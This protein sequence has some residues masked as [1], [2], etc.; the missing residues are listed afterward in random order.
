MTDLTLQKLLY[1]KHGQLLTKC[2]DFALC[3]TIYGPQRVGALLL[4]KV[5]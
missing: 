4:E 3:M 2:S 1:E 5:Q